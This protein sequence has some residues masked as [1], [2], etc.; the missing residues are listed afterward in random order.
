M[1]LKT[2]N[3]LTAAVDAQLN[4]SEEDLRRIERGIRDGAHVTSDLVLLLVREIRQL[5]EESRGMLG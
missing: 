5:R 3:L 1:P 4:F 2:R